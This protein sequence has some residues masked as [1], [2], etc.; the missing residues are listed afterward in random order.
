[1]DSDF[2]ADISGGS[3]C[4]LLSCEVSGQTI[5]AVFAYWA[6]KQRGEMHLQN[7]RGERIIIAVP[8][9]VW[10]LKSDEFL[11]KAE[12]PILGKQDAD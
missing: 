3:L 4:Y 10:E 12:Y 7:E 2:F 1:M 11:Y 9:F 6:A 8:A 5:K